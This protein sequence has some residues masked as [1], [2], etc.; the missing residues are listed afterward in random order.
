MHESP[1]PCTLQCVFPVLLWRLQADDPGPLTA[2]Q[3]ESQLASAQEEREK[4]AR[5]MR[6]FKREGGDVIDTPHLHL[7]DKTA[8][9][10]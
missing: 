3:L 6:E 10:M 1:S 4:S 5:L 7:R 2:D 8:G 9:Q